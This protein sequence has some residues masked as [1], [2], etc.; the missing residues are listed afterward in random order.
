MRWALLL[1][2]KAS[3]CAISARRTVLLVVYVSID[4]RWIVRSE[5]NVHRRKTCF[6]IFREGELFMCVRA[7]KRIDGIEASQSFI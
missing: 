2:R 5:V 6:C 3:G 4:M 7:T 1:R